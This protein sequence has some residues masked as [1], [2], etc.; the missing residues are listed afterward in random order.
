MIRNDDDLE[1]VDRLM[2]S[3]VQPVGFLSRCH[4][5][6][7]AARAV[8]RARDR[9]AAAPIAVAGIRGMLDEAAGD[10]SDAVANWAGLDFA[11]PLSKEFARAWGRLASSLRMARD[12]AMISLRLTVAEATGRPVL[13]AAMRFRGGTQTVQSEWDR[14]GEAAEG[15]AAAWPDNAKSTLNQSLAAFAEAFSRG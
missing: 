2:A 13:A 11:A 1:W 4:K 9:L 12:L 3:L 8:S 7:A 14:I 5:Q 6:G 15:E 10:S